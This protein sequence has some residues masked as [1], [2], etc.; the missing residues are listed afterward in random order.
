MLHCFAYTKCLQLIFF[1]KNLR[2]EATYMYHFQ[3]LFRNVTI[4]VFTLNQCFYKALYGKLHEFY[5]N[6]AKA[7]K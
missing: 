5:V 6:R 2:M 7:G 3:S 4:H 1:L